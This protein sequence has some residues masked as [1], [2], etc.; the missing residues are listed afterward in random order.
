MTLSLTVAFIWLAVTEKID[1]GLFANTYGIIITFWF[2]QRAAPNTRSGDTTT[3]VTT[4]PPATTITT[5]A[6]AAP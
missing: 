3:T 6:P 4:P 1:A 5:S 2:A